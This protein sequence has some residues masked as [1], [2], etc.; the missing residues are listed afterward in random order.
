MSDYNSFDGAHNKRSTPNPSTQNNNHKQKSPPHFYS[1]PAVS[2]PLITAFGLP[3]L[4]QCLPPSA[5]PDAPPSP[6][7]TF[8]RARNRS[9]SLPAVSPSKG[10]NNDQLPLQPQQTNSV[11]Q[12]TESINAYTYRVRTLDAISSDEHRLRLCQ[13]PDGTYSHET[14]MQ[15]NNTNE[16]G[17]D[18]VAESDT[19]LLM[20]QDLKASVSLDTVTNL[21]E[22]LMDMDRG[23]LP[24][25]VHP[26]IPQEMLDPQFIRTTPTL[27]LWPLAVLVFYNVSGGPFGIE[28]SIR[29]GGNFYAIL[30]FILF[31]LVW[32]VPEALVTAELGAAFQDPAAGVAWVEEAFGESM[33]GVCG[34][35]AWVSGAT[36]NAIYPT[37]FMEYVSSVAGWDKDDFGGWTRFGSVAA[38]TICLAYLNYSGLEIVGKASLAVC[39]LAMSPFLILTI[40]GAPKVVPSRWLQMPEQPED[41]T[42]LFDDDFQ[43]S[44]GPFPFL[45]LGGILWRPYLNNMFWNLNSF[46]SAAS[47]AAE[48]SSASTT[49]PRGIF[50]GLVMSVV[51]YIV[52]LMVANGATDYNQSEWVDGHLG[53]VAVDIGGRWLGGWTIFAAGI[54]NLALFEAEMSSDAFQLMGMAERG[55]LPKIF[56]TRSKFGTPTAGIVFNT[57]VIV[58]FSCA[59]FGQLLELLNSV[60]AMSL[61]MEYAAFVKLRLYHKELQRPYRIPVPDWAAVLIVMPPT[62]GI[63]FVFATSNW[64]VYYFCAGALFFG[65]I[66]FKLSEVSKKRGWLAYE[67]KARH[68]QYDMPPLNDDDATEPTEGISTS[69]PTESDPSSECSNESLLPEN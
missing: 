67:S 60:Y 32:S 1:T 9:P 49:F 10:R 28:P 56:Q 65:I 66:L 52:P 46:D 69:T 24:P 64:Y 54:S 35:L 7:F 42:E 12:S 6:Q 14:I 2:A 61:L 30:G 18:D 26:S 16:H 8:F 59:D 23:V 47:F 21:E 57:I 51:S 40:I 19:G 39:I 58:A 4:I 68:N 11:D 29:A 20:S 45:S 5:L 15:S 41:D 55:Y 63:L 36:D 43:T 37:L 13:N 22:T 62:I 50:I 31:P 27:K 17:K 38:I 44:P 53:A 34:Y 48:T 33:A 25:H 3:T